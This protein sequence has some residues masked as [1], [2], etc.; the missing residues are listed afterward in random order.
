MRTMD[1]KEIRELINEWSWCT[2]VGTDGNIPYAIEV[3]YV[4]D[5]EYVYCGSRPGGSMHKCLKKNNNLVLKVCD[6]DKT[7]PTWRAVAVRG[8]A[9]FINDRE[10]VYRILRLVA[11][12]RGQKE[13]SFDKVAEYIL[14]NPDGTS[15]FRVP[16]KDITGVTRDQPI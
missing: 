9:E 12:V 6:A 3:T 10:E 7:Y 13:D 4:N 15:L 2:I 14:N 11:K 16:I 1:E 5:G 8:K